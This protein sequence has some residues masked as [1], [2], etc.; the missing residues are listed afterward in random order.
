MK[1]AEFESELFAF[2]NGRY[3]DQVDALLLFL[4]WFLES[5]QYLQPLLFAMPIVVSRPRNFPE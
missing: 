5:G 2:P 3:D 1:V 4:D